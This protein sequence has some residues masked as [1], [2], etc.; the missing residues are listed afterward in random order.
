MESRGWPISRGDLDPFYGQANEILEL[1]PFD[2]DPMHWERAAS[3]HRLPI[4]A[5]EMML[6]RMVQ[7]GWIEVQG[8][9]HNTVVR[10]TPAGLEAMRSPV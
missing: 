3:A 1:G 4:P 9:D 5:E 2:Y 10:L 8:K 6:G 7:Q